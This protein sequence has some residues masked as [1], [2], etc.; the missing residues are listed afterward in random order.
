MSFDNISVL[1]LPT[2]IFSLFI[3]IGNPLIVMIL[4]RQ[5]NYNKRTS[6]FAG[7]TVAQISEFS[8]IL[9]MLGVKLGHVQNDILSLVTLVGLITI[10]GSTYMIIYAETIYDKISGWLEIFEKK[11]TKEIKNIIEKYDIILFGHNRIGYDFI[12][13]FNKIKKDFLVVDFDPQIIKYLNNKKIPNRYGD[14]DDNEFL[15][16]LN[17]EKIKMAVSTIPEYKTNLLL[18]KK[19][20]QVNKK[21]VI[22]SISHNI[23]EAEKLYKKGASYV[24]LPHFLGGK[25]ASGIIKKFNFKKS[26]YT[27]EREKHLRYLEQRKKIGHEHPIH[28]KYR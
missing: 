12:K 13:S 15:N 16:E 22:I 3:L 18:I 28:E 27:K 10:A 4:M 21:A 5:L 25:Y 9:L 14:A 26:E 1:I 6:F 11:K 20:R 24:I 23:S 17:L 2:I 8:L 19:I 7:L